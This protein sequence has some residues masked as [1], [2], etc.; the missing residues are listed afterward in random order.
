M[1]SG[2]L[3]L[4]G[5]FPAFAD[6]P[7]ALADMTFADRV[8]RREGRSTRDPDPPRRRPTPRRGSWSSAGL[9]VGETQFTDLSRTPDPLV[10]G[11]GRRRPRARPVHAA[12]PKASRPGSRRSRPVR[13]PTARATSSAR[14]ASQRR[15]YGRL[16]D[17]DREESAIEGRRSLHRPRRWSR[18]ANSG[19]SRSPRR[20]AS[21]T[22]PGQPRAARAR[23]KVAAAAEG[24]RARLPRLRRVLRRLPVAAAAARPGDRPARRRRPGDQAAGTHACRVDAPAAPLD[25]GGGGAAVDALRARRPALPRRAARRR[26]ASSSTARS[27]SRRAATS[28]VNQID[29]DGSVLKTGRLRRATLSRSTT[30]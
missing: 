1:A 20:T 30:T 26:R 2:S 25:E 12:W 14:S 13:S 27:G 15:Y 23:R 21:T 19:G 11:R 5:E 22:G 24:A 18:P 17:A 8:R 4:D 28:V 29:V 3:P 7:A 9:G 16:D 10:P 6:W